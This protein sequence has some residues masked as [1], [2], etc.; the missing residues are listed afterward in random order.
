MR[1]LAWIIGWPLFVTYVIV[2]LIAHGSHKR[3]HMLAFVWLVLGPAC[4]VEGP[5]PSPSESSD[6]GVDESSTG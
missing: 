3:M 1:A 5:N 6:S 2:T 4:Y